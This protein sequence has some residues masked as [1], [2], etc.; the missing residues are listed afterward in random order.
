MRAAATW[1][2]ITHAYYLQK[3]DLNEDAMDQLQGIAEKSHSRFH[4]LYKDLP[5]GM[6]IRTS[7]A[8]NKFTVGSAAHLLD[9]LHKLKKHQEEK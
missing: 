7:I 6:S 9:E 4:A 8:I 2:I 3:G 1:Q 5:E